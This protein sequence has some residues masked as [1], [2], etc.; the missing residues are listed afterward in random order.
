MGGATG[1]GGQGGGLDIP[2]WL[3]SLFGHKNGNQDQSGGYAGTGNPA[4]AQYTTPAYMSGAT[5]GGNADI[6]SSGADSGAN[7]LK[8][9]SGGFNQS[10]YAAPE[11]LS[12]VNTVPHDDITGGQQGQQNP[13]IAGILAAINNQSPYDS[14]PYMQ[15]LD[16]ARASSL[17]AIAGAEDRTNANFN[18]SNQAIGNI[19]AKGKQDTL[20]DNNVLKSNNADLVGG[21]NSM[22][23]GATKGLQDDR[24][25]EMADQVAMDQALGIQQAGLGTAGQTQ[26]KA[27]ANA[28]QAQQA[29]VDKALQY[30]GAD[31][32]E[33]TARADGLI[34]EGASRQ[35]ALRSQL[36]GVLG[37]LDSKKIDVDNTYQNNAM[38]ARNQAYQDNLSK[39]SALYGMYDKELT[40][41]D[42]RYKTDQNS[43]TQAALITAEGK[44]A[45]NGGSG[46]GGQTNIQDANSFVQSQGGNPADYNNAYSGA[47]MDAGTPAGMQPTE[48][49]LLK[50][51]MA[52][53]PHLDLTQAIQYIRNA[54]NASKYNSPNNSGIA[55]LAN[56]V[57]AG[58]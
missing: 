24:H 48:T 22:Y 38:Q 50:G 56:Q 2:G 57:M 43:R 37:Q 3:N 8:A 5:G 11:S 39:M 33:N 9:L 41:S 28:S 44:L 42:N 6:G 20:A 31:L 25:K 30:G 17:K 51:M 40:R 1:G 58:Q 36:A 29:S 14:G 27:I 18:T 54:S 7:A 53:N 46:S 23:A 13:M 34:S 45:A 55:M 47:I 16:A 52:K 49:D 10:S 26:T 19:Y 32:T 35:A 12:A 15:N 4:P 21:L